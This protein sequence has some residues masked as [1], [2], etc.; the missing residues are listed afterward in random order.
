[1]MWDYCHGCGGVPSDPYSGVCKTCE[2]RY[3]LALEQHQAPNEADN[4]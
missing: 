3:P 1:M 4:G 2:P